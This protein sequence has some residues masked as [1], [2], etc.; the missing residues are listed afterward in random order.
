MTRRSVAGPDEPIASA[1]R[2]RRTAF[3]LL[4]VCG[5]LH[6]PD[7]SDAPAAASMAAFAATD[8]NLSP[9][10]LVEHVLS[11]YALD[12]IG[13]CRLH[14]RGLND[15]YK[16]ETKRGETYYLR[17]YYAGRRSREAI[18][19][20][21]AMLSHL[22]QQNVTVSA[23]LSR[24]D[25]AILTPLDC[26]EGR[27]WAVLFPAAP[28][29]ELRRKKY[30][31]ELAARYGETAAAIHCAAESFKG[32]QRRPALDLELL[33]EQPLRRVTSAIAHR[34]QDVAYVE[35]LSERLRR[36]I[37]RAAG[38]E[39]GFCHGDFH[40]GNSGESDGSFTIFD[41]D[42]CGWGY[43]AYDL[44]VFPWGFAV[45][46]CTTERVEAMGRSFLA[47][48]MRRRMLADNDIDAI[49]AFVAIREIWLL[50]LHLDIGD[51]F[52]WGWINDGY[53]DH[54]FKMLREW[55][56]SALDRPGTAWLR[57]GDDSRTDA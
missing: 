14:S 52:G 11:R 43:R 53:F 36:R 55:D 4:Q 34:P 17:V 57:P 26:I 40:G 18:E 12:A 27:R 16:V 1:P 31:D 7:L 28:G 41:F 38:L 19:T 20:E 23:P 10:A 13:R 46:E 3:N 42:C 22:A 15:T 47:G 49:P 45:D 30:T 9:G 29:K 44:A 24:T 8:S 5:T 2:F 51:Q 25:G 48:Y 32:P 33:L 37:R 21:I 54:H 39:I 35:E 50:G 56:K 6:M